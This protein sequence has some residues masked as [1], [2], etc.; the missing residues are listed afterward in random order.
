ML[1]IAEGKLATHARSLQF[2][3]VR[4]PQVSIII[5][6]YNND[7]LTIECLTSILKHTKNMSY[8]IIVIDDGSAEKTKDVLS[9]IKN[10][11]YLRN[12]Q[13]LEFLLSCNCAAQKARGKFLSLK[14]GCLPW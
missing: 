9:Q 10:I 13:N 6:V 1:S 12:P 14:A 2:P 5:P 11:I 8:E 4:D 3:A 7:R